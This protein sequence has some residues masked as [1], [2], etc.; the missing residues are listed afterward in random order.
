MQSSYDFYLIKNNML[1]DCIPFALS[2]HWRIEVKNCLTNFYSVNWSHNKYNSMKKTINV[3][4]VSFTEMYHNIVLDFKNFVSI[5]AVKWR[6][7]TIFSSVFEHKCHY[8]IHQPNYKIKQIIKHEIFFQFFTWRRKTLSKSLE[9]KNRKSYGPS[10]FSL[11]GAVPANSSHRNGR[12]SRRCF[13]YCRTYKLRVSTV[14]R[15]H[16]YAKRKGFVVIRP[17]DCTHLVARDSIK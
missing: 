13:E 17:S 14:R 15:N 4:L 8:C 12:Q 11:L 2:A 5:F 16:R 7:W 10:I 6:V 3:N 1:N 9:R